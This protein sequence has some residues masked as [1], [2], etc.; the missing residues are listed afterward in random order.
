MKS[1]QTMLDRVCNSIIS[2]NLEYKDTIII[3][4]NSSGKSDVLRQFI[5]NDKE[6]K[7]YFIDAVNRY[8]DIE[9]ITPDPVLG[10]AFRHEFTD[11]EL[12]VLREL[13]CGDTDEEIAATLHLSTWTVRK[14][15]KQMLEKT[16]FKSRTQLAVAARECGLVIKGY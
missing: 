2:G 1:Y 5:Q 13:T 4:D 16:D 14:Y 10:Q 15:V 8:F 11:Q 3:G 7:F 9:Q 6:E 12:R